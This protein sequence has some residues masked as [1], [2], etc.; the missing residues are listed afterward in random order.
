MLRSLYSG[1]AG[2][3]TQQVKMDVIGNNIAN[4]ST[5][6][7]KSSRATF[8]DVYY[9]TT[10][11]ATEASV[12]AGG[13]NPTQ[14]GYGNTLASI[15]VNT[16]QSAMSTTG[17]TLD[18]AI[19]GDGYFQVMD[20]SG[21]IFYTKAG[22]FDIDAQGNVVDSNGY[23][24]LGVSG[25]PSGQ[26]A[27]KNKIKVQLPYE[28]AS[29][30]TASDTLNNILYTLKSANETAAAN[31]NVS[32]VS[33]KALPI[34]QKAQATITSSS[35]VVTLNANE[36]F[37]SLEAVNAA[38]NEA[39]IA[40]NGG[41]ELASGRMTLSMDDPSKFTSGITGAQVVNA[42]FGVQSGKIAVTG[43]LGDF[44]A[45]STVGDGFSGTGTADLTLALDADNN[46]TITAGDYTATVTAAQMAQAG[47]VLLKKGGSTT[48]AFVISY[49]ALTTIT[50][51]NLTGM[52]GSLN[53]EPSTA[54]INLGLG[55]GVFAMKGGTEGG[56]QTVADLT[57]ISI[58]D[59][60]VIT[61]SHPTFGLVEIGRIDLASFANPAGLAQ[62]GNT[63]FEV[64]KNSG[65]PLLTRA[66]ENGTGELVSGTLESSNVD[67]SNEFADMIVTQRGF[68][69]ASRM[70]TVSDTM[71]EELINLKR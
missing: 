46:L 68:Q 44:F 61:A 15:D 34:G 67:L 32:F 51:N 18:A 2:M 27:S 45:V 11:G 53:M 66:G 30:A 10:S 16:S 43:Q 8:R 41:L 63:Y 42:D 9:Q 52:T 58:G 7:Y 71:L 28:S 6:G 20:N 25:T 49:P 48:D 65:D 33:S 39:L 12:V 17:Y 26:P 3:K 54:S 1:V 13:T 69:A 23:F 37:D 47:S 60:G 62:T 31:L 56:E 22:I 38:V 24:V 40:A 14:I 50:A 35:I 29:E 64:T 70:I 59:D 36:T 19:A 55:N 5:Y 4:V 57:G 21:N